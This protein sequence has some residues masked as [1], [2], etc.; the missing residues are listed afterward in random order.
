MCSED[1]LNK[2]FNLINT[3]NNHVV[4]WSVYGL[5]VVEKIS[6]YIRMLFK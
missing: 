2:I 5:F 3:S 1:T 6:F 4:L